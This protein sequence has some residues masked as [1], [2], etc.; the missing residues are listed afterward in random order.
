M[1]CEVAVE[2]FLR[3]AKSIPEDTVA[4]DTSIQDSESG[5]EDD[6]DSDSDSDSSDGE[7]DDEVSI[8][9][10]PWNTVLARY[11]YTRRASPSVLLY[12]V[13]VGEKF[14]LQIFNTLLLTKNE[15]G[16]L[17]LQRMG[18]DLFK[19]VGNSCVTVVVKWGYAALLK[20]IISHA[21]MTNATYRD[22]LAK[23]ESNGRLDNFCSSHAKDLFLTSR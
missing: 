6:S 18:A 9:T 12:G 3:I 20:E 22:E 23:S 2:D 4:P 8:Y 16:I 11:A 10:A 5:S 19:P 13:V 7:S 15:R 17:E 14:D 21:Q 1:G